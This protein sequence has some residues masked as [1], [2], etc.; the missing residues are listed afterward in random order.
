MHER[1]KQHSPL[2]LARAAQR[3]RDE[4]DLLCALE[5]RGALA[6]R[7]PAAG[8]DVEAWLM[9][10]TGRPAP[11]AG[12]LI[13]AL[14]DA[15]LAPGRALFQVVLHVEPQPVAGDGIARLSHELHSLLA[16]CQEAAQSL[17]LRLV[18]IGI[19][20]TVDDADL[21]APNMTA[22]A[23][24]SGT[25]A[26]RR[27]EIAGVR[28]R[29]STAH[30]GIV[31]GAAVTSL[32]ARL[33]VAPE[34][35]P[36]FHNASIIAAFAA[37]G[38]AANAPYLF[39]VELWEDTRVAL[40]ED[41]D[42][43]DDGAERAQPFVASLDEYLRAVREFPTL[44]AAAAEAPQ[45][46]AQL[47]CHVERLPLWSRLQVG[48]CEDGTPQLLIEQHAMS[49][50]P[51][52]ADMVANL[53]FHFGLT[54]S[55][56]TEADPPELALDAAAIQANLRAVA[57]T[58]LGAEV[59]WLDKERMP[60]RSLAIVELIERAYDGLHQLGVDEEVAQRHLSLIERRVAGGQTGAVWQRRFVQAHGRNF[61]LLAREYAAR[62]LG[63]A[64]VHEWNLRRLT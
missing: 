62:Q 55:L 64:P 23:E 18:T 8:L 37:A 25:F 59:A 44:A 35:A 27:I 32:R 10:R 60:L 19:L 22:E 5:A 49:A 38:L 13:A 6:R 29:I 34:V 26:P 43:A 24:R 31:P 30:R 40:L 50:G 12:A 39:G 11:Q 3:L 54:A 56:A 17:Q 58:G 45:R 63:G 20:P 41:G 21:A 52:P 16:R 2:D 46:F 15:A 14:P 1:S 4:T 28:E 57:R 51:T 36:R 61:A 9:D 53:C 48:I 33:Q 47:R 42:A 7:A